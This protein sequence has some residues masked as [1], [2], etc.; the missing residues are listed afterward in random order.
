MP[1]CG[2]NQDLRNV[3]NICGR[4][5]DTA[6]SLATSPN[7]RA[8]NSRK[9]IET[10]PFPNSEFLSFTNIPRRNPI[11]KRNPTLLLNPNYKHV[12]L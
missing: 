8:R 9:Y 11:P 4:L 12:T 2:I 6:W 10:N 5:N 1:V 7:L 3:T